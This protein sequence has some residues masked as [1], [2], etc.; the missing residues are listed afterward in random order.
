MG[1]SSTFFPRDHLSEELKA[2]LPLAPWPEVAARLR[3]GTRRP[4]GRAVLSSCV[5]SSRD[6][7]G[8]PTAEN[9]LIRA[10][11]TWPQPPDPLSLGAARVSGGAGGGGG[12]RSVFNLGG[13]AERWRGFVGDLAGLPSLPC[14]GPGDTDGNKTPA[15]T[16]APFITQFPEFHPLPAAQ[17][18]QCLLAREGAGT[19]G[20]SP[21]H[22]SPFSDPKCHRDHLRGFL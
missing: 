4:P 13:F 5:P 18:R 16:L 7:E 14:Q 9:P 19:R 12:V 20:R 3:V 1:T 15:V 10:R 6:N 11:G 2:P 22:V 21:V 8:L 17:R